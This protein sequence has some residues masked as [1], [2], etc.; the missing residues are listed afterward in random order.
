MKVL[1]KNLT[2]VSLA[3]TLASSCVSCSDDDENILT[4]GADVAP[5]A[6]V[7]INGIPTNVNGAT[8][9]LNTKGQVVKIKSA[10]ETVT[11]E[12]GSF[13]RSTDYSVVMKVR[14]GSESNYGSDYYLQLNKQGFITYAYQEEY[15]EGDTEPEGNWWF[16]YNKAGQM[17][18][19]KHD[20]DDYVEK[21]TLAYSNGDVTKVNYI[22]EDR[23]TSETTVEYVNDKHTSP[24]ENNGCIMLFED[25]LGIDMDEM[26]IA[27]FAGLLGKATKNLPM[28]YTESYK[29]HGSE[30][31]DTYDFNWTFND[32]GLPI[33]FQIG[34][35]E[36]SSIKFTW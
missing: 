36:R 33:S 3:I 13:S 7:F 25:A 9:E 14:E 27:Y 1:L 23:E 21:Y 24:V 18:M 20:D 35:D 28:R 19:F 16:E 4:N 6:S 12:Y 26:E 31:T 29:S 32:R 11:F 2:K 15:D 30:Y 17:T 10:N 8:I 34:D 22:D 5:A